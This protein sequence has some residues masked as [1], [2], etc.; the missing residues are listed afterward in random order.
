MTEKTERPSSLIVKANVPPYFKN[1]L[2]LLETAMLI[3]LL[4]IYDISHVMPA[5]IDDYNIASPLA[6]ADVRST[7]S[8]R[9]AKKG[10]I[11][12]Q[13]TRRSLILL[14]GSEKK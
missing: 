9:K 2:C 1:T 8:N 6:S 7:S 13:F 12:F 10:S 4:E 11:L 14:L 5:G 3:S